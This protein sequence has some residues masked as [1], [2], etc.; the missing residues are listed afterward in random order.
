M[1]GKSGRRHD[2]ADRPSAL[3][4]PPHQKRAPEQQQQEACYQLGDNQLS[5]AELLHLF[6]VR[7]SLTRITGDGDEGHHVREAEGGA[8]ALQK[9]FDNLEDA[10]RLASQVQSS[11]QRSGAAKQSFPKPTRQLFSFGLGSP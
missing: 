3:L 6:G 5:Q 11:P 7:R 9:A 1:A 4:H 8:T 2:G 10:W